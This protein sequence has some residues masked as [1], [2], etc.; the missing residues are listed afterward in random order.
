MLSLVVSY[1]GFRYTLAGRLD[2]GDVLGVCK[3][4]DIV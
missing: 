4:S 3:K 1:R 2:E